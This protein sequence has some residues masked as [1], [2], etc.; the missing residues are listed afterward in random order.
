MELYELV[1]AEGLRRI[2]LREVSSLELTEA[3]LSRLDEVL[4]N[5]VFCHGDR[6]PCDRHGTDTDR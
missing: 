2:R 5:S 4:S 1:V 3:V 6:R